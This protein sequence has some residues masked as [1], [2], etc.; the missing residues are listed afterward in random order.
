VNKKEEMAMETRK[1][2]HEANEV[3]PESGYIKEVPDP[4]EDLGDVG[5]FEKPALLGVTKELQQM[6]NY[7]DAWKFFSEHFHDFFDSR[8]GI[9]YG[10]GAFEMWWTGAKVDPDCAPSPEKPIT[11]EDID[12]LLQIREYQN[13]GG[14]VFGLF[15]NCFYSNKLGRVMNYDTLVYLTQ[16]AMQVARNLDAVE[17]LSS[18]F[19]VFEG[20]DESEIEEILD[21]PPARKLAAQQIATQIKQDTTP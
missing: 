21:S 13:Q 1:R 6:P 8:S 2:W 17:T 9:P 5:D 7:F 11:K 16:K 14:E 15:M 4:L 20:M 10:S 19:H 3:N 18:G 12:K